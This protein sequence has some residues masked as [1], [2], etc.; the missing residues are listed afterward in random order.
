M[1]SYVRESLLIKKSGAVFLLLLGILLTV[2]GLHEES[3]P[4]VAVGFLSLLGGILLLVLKF[5]RR[6][7]GNLL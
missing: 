6:N 4:V 3:S 7:Q 5:V 1:A 2:V